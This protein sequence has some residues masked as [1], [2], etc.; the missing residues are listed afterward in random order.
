M[1]FRVAKFSHLANYPDHVTGHSCFDDAP[2][3]R[4]TL[5]SVGVLP[6]DMTD[7][8]D[9]FPDEDPFPDDM[10][11]PELIMEATVRVLA[12]E[13]YRG[14]TLRKVAEK[15]GKNRGLVHYYFDSKADLLRSLLDHIL[16][17]TRRLIG[18]DDEDDPVDQ[19]W[20][21]LRF[22]AFGP[23]G[24]DEAGRHYY[25]AIFQLQ[26]LA[27]HDAEIRRRFSRNRRYTVELTASLVQE[28][29][30]DGT[31]RPVDP[32]QTA[33]FLLAAID[34]ARNVDIALDEDTTREDVLATVDRF[35]AEMLRA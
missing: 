5:N 17:G 19:L 32:E 3:R 28:A 35:V 15:A 20:T 18:I 22:H 1:L 29:I 7:G 16:D 27:V 24:V 2:S 21:A 34:G 9:S 33:V 31:F 26:A 12:E 10:E 4:H 8:G 6:H 11:P 30:N 23:G 13:G 25:V 14:L